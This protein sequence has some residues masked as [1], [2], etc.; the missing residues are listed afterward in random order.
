M[1]SVVLLVHLD[2]PWSA[3]SGVWLHKV[4]QAGSRWTRSGPGALAGPWCW[5]VD[6]WCSGLQWSTKKPFP[7]TI[8]D[9]SDM[10]K[11]V[12]NGGNRPPPPQQGVL[13]AP[14]GEDSDDD[15]EGSRK[16]RRN[17]RPARI[18]RRPE[19]DD[20]DDKED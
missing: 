10:A 4:D 2:P 14:G 7:D 13:G 20:N 15:K 5:V 16:G 19:D 6:Q 12:G 1:V 18:S 11:R 3:I 9:Q 17:E 8:S